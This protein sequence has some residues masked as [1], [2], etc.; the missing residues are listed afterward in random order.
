ME[1]WSKRSR[2]KSRLSF[3]TPRDISSSAAVADIGRLH[4]SGFLAWL[5]WLFVHLIFLIG[6]ENRLLVLTQWAWNY[7]TRNRA[8]QLITGEDVSRLAAADEPG[9]LDQR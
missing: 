8:A 1:F 9:T 4:F 3:Y 5:A 7:I 2:R 6:F